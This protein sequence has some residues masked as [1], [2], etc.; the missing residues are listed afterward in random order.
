[1]LMHSM[2]CPHT[3]TCEVENNEMFPVC[4]TITSQYNYFVYWGN[5]EDHVQLTNFIFNLCFPMK[6]YHC[7][8]Q[9]G[10]EFVKLF[11]NLQSLCISLLSTGI[12]V[13]NYHLQM[14]KAFKKLM[15]LNVFHG[16]GILQRY[17]WSFFFSSHICYNITILMLSSVF[18]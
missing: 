10:L 16:S 6:S 2:V 8:A 11:S 12:T 3:Q 17:F 13:L 14:T 4:L 1:M 9:A 7:V 15:I 18:A 5:W